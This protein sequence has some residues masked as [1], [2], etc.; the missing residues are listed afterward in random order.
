MASKH[1]YDKKH[2]NTIFKEATLQP[3]VIEKMTRPYEA[4]PWHLYKKLFITDKRVR[5]GVAFWNQNSKT[6]DSVSKRYGVPASV[7]VAI[8]GVESNYGTQPY[9]F[10][11]IDALTTL[12]FAYPSRSKF[13]RS[14]LRHYLL[15]TRKKEL[16]PLLI[17]GSYAG[18]IGLPQF[19]PSSYRSYAINFS[20]TDTISLRDNHDDAIASVA[21]F[22][23]AH[24]WVRGKPIA[25]PATITG[26][27]HMALKELKLSSRY[28]VSVLKKYGIKPKTALT[29][30]QKVMLIR[31][32]RKKGVEYWL[33]L[34][35]F[36]A[37]T[38]YNHS[39]LYAM[40]VFQLAEQIQKSRQLA[41]EKHQN[42][43]KKR[44]THG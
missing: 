31:L 32:K 41:L 5:K 18:A 43:S 19:M 34:K 26:K 10:R 44:D 35:N 36:R 28:R 15:L 16:D 30:N 27:R 8:I 23:K 25:I 11:I 37:I 40:A 22:L 21:N 4:K 39:K 6:L 38:R 13:F 7:I 14:E 29:P 1:H 20:G 3:K 12:A 33:G 42:L 2:L 24:G 17:Y 9:E